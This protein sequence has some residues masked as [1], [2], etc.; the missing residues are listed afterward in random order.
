MRSTYYPRCMAIIS[1]ILDG[2]GAAD[3]RIVDVVAPSH[4]TVTLS[5]LNAADTWELI[6]DSRALSFDPDIL[7]SVAVQIYLFAAA[8]NDDDRAFWTD[9][10]NLVLEGLNDE[11]EIEVSASG[12]W[13][14]MTGRDLTGIMLDIQWQPRERIPTGIAISQAFQKVIDDNVPSSGPFASRF[15]VSYESD[16]VEPVVGRGYR[17][18]KRRGQHVQPGK[19]IW[20]VL[21]KLARQY[22]FLA[23]VDGSIIRIT[24]PRIQTVASLRRA[25][26]MVYGRN[27]ANLKI[28]R[29]YARD[30]V[31]TIIVTSYDPRTKTSI[32]EQWPPKGGTVDTALGIKKNED[33]RVFAPDGITD[34]ATLRRFARTKAENLGRAEAEYSWK[35]RDLVSLSSDRDAVSDEGPSLLRLRYGDAVNVQFDPFNAESARSLRPPQ[36]VE[37]MRA[38]GY[39]AEVARVVAAS[40]ARLQQ[41]QQPYYTRKVQY[42]YAADGGLSISWEGLNYAFVPRE[43]ART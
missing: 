14:R 34:R 11:G 22:G 40:F 35:T 41:Y 18:P 38:L 2:R 31:P 33:Q 13:V 6:F 12:G 37:H 21:Y 17:A 3:D 27:L 4:A 7:L 8:S 32:R 9:P 30:R 24:E 20:D 36:L 15:T 43:E 26:L 10:A 19:S 28:R 42:D 5:G 29:R 25:P 23:Y 16:D 39:T 1:A